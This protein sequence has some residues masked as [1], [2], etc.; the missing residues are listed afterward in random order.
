[1]IGVSILIF[2]LAATAVALAVNGVSQSRQRAGYERSLA[3]AETGIDRVLSE[4]QGA[5]TSFNADYPAPGPVSLVEPSPWCAGTAVNFPSAGEGAGGIFSTEAAERTWARTKLEG[6]IAAGTC[7]QTGGGGQYVVLKPVSTS[8]KYGRVYSLSAVPT[9]ADPTARARLVKSEY[10]FMPYRP[11]HAIL[12]AGPLVISSSTTVTA[13]YGVDPTVASVHSN[14]TIT[15]TG[16]PSVSGLVTSTGTSTFSSNGFTL[17]PGGAVAQKP[18]EAIPLVSARTFYTQA[19]TN[20]PAAVV[21]WYDLCTDGS[22]RNYASTGPCTG[23]SIGTASS[24]QEVRG[25]NYA[26]RTWTATRNTLSGT[27]Y[28]FQS[29][30]VAGNGNGTFA[31][32]TL[33]AESESSTVCAAKRYGNIS[34]DHFTIT[35]PAYHNLW[36]FA[37]TDIV[38]TSNFSAGSFGPPVVSGMFVAGDQIQMETSSQGAVG[39]VVTANLCTTPAG[40]G[41]LVSTSEVKNPAV[42]FDPNSDAPFSSI[43][44]TSLWL[45]YSGG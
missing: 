8:F 11:S 14:A 29:D 43:I 3:L 44:T 38:T 1:M 37:D 9:F 28:A 26:S 33:V 41:G 40:G 30:I 32:L 18:T 22:M 6:L 5:Y 4:V 35:S 42:Y 20:D 23:T 10:I 34:W 16:N 39:S 7:I 45:D 17:N 31:R 19:A 2:T 12:A 36:M 15:G 25:W 21:D 24:S 13:A 27:Y